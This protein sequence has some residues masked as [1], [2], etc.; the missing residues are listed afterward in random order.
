MID[1]NRGFNLQVIDSKT[2]KEIPVENFVILEQ[3]EY[4]T[5]HLNTT[6]NSKKENNMKTEQKQKKQFTKKQIQEAIKH[7]KGVLKQMNE[8][9][10]PGT[11]VVGEP[12]DINK[13]VSEDS[14]ILVGNAKEFKEETSIADIVGD[15]NFGVYCLGYFIKCKSYDEMAEVVAELKRLQD[16]YDQMYS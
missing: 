11:V 7:W 10:L 12:S 6:T 3:S 13:E 8:S 4:L 14:D 16:E 1:T 5:M 15:D 9:R 2:A